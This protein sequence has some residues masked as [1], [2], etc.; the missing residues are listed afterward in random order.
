MLRSKLFVADEDH[1]M[2]HVYNI[3]VATHGCAISD[4][5]SSF[6]KPRQRRYAKV[7]DF[8]DRG[9]QLYICVSHS[10]YSVTQ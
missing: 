1:M 10:V 6:R 4:D 7:F 9:I 5:S 3:F 2:L 8:F